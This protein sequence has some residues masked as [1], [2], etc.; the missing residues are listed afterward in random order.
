MRTLRVAEGL[1]LEVLPGDG[2]EL[3]VARLRGL[4]AERGDETMGT[5]V[6]RAEEIDALMSALAEAAE[7]LEGG[8]FGARV[9]VS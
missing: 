4:T 5:V 6:I 2:R 1:I 7:M 3:P 8:R 9:R